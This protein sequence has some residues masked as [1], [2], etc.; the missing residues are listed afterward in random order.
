MPSLLRAFELS[1]RAAQVGFDWKTQGDVIDKAE[2][3]IKELREA[4]AN[5]GGTSDAR[6]RRIRRPALLARQRRAQARHRA[7]GGA[8][9]GERQVSAA[10]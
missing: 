2:E 8:A 3:E 1:T 7:R 5:G 9:R 10:L 4:V 6:R